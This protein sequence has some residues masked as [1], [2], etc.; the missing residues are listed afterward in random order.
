VSVR[1]LKF[2]FSSFLFCH[3]P[4]PPP[5]GVSKVRNKRSVS[6]IAGLFCLYSSSPLP[7]VPN[8]RSLSWVPNKCAYAFLVN[9]N[10]WV[11]NTWVPNKRSLSKVREVVRRQR[12]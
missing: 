11:T 5:Y 10:K 6:R 8:K 4:P 2:L 1:C 12:C 3:G 7:G 9:D